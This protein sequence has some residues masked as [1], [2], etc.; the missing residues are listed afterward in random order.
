MVPTR[1]A[2]RLAVGCVALLTST[3]LLSVTPAQAHNPVRPGGDPSVGATKPKPN[4][5]PVGVGER[6]EVARPTPTPPAPLPKVSGSVPIDKGLRIAPGPDT[7]QASP[8]GRAATNAVTDKV[9]VRALVIA[10]DSA[11]FGLAT[12]KKT[13]DRV[14]AAYDVLLARSTPLTAA[15]LINPDGTGRYSAI[16]LSSASLLYSDDNINWTSAFDGTEW[17]TLWAYERDY[18]VRQAVLYASYGTYP[19]DYCLQGVSEG[20]VGATPL[21]SQLTTAGSQIFDYL[22]TNAQVPITDSYVYRNSVRAGCTATPVL[23]GGG[24]TLGVLSPSTDGRQRMA[25][26]FTSNEYLLQADLLVYGLFRWAS[27]GLFLGDQR[28]Y[29][30]VDVDDW[31][32]SADHYQANGTVVP[33]G[34]SMSAHDAYNTY[35]RQTALRSRYPLANN[36]TINMAYNGGDADLTAPSTCYPNGTVAQLTATTRCLSPQFRWLN[37]TL[38][39]PEMNHTNY[40]T[41][42]AEVNNNVTVGGTLGLT[43]DR[44]V[45]KT[46][47]Y[48]GLGVYHPDPDNDVDPPTDYGLEASNPAFLL[49]SRNAGV[50]Y[51]HGNMS[52]PSHQPSCFNCAIAHP[53]EPAL[54]VVPDWPTNIAYHTTTPAEQTHFYNSFYGPNGKFPFWPTDR[55]Y[56]QMLSYET[57]VALSHM[58]SGSLYT[59]TFHIANLRNYGSGKTLLDDWLDSLLAKYSNYY[60]VPVLNPDWGTLGALSAARTNHFAR[61]AGGANAVWDRATNQVTVTSPTA[62]TVTVS[63]ARTT[64]FSTYGTDVSAPVTLTAGGTVTFTPSLRP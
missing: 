1:R 32:N 57:D 36:F 8:D 47:E 35:L 52:F 6:P 64:G 63:G 58:T 21:V 41:S 25:L 13:L 62:G 60:K 17:N 54:W 29:L 38:T 27:R 43:V 34:Y 56:A 23:T 49:A 7:R 59:H 14:G 31:F 46:G 2:R 28:H 19:E 51:L 18:A 22:K 10:L 24:N 44:T 48:S 42:Y 61:L 12:W 50:K 3:A 16:L 15:N 39:H 45:L 55:T 20:A 30:N 26:T 33:D 40:A 37:H 11:D 9:G 53:L 5:P 4:R